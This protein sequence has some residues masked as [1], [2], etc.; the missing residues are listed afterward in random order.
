ME[1]TE[2]LL[3]LVALLLDAKEPLTWKQIR[4]A[5]PDDY[6]QG[7]VEATERK[8]ERDKAELLELG[9]PIKYTQAAEDVD[10]GYTLD[11]DA[12]YLPKLQLGPDEMAVLYAAGSAAL[13][14][15]AFPGSSDLAHALRKI[16]FFA[17]P[18]PPA[19]KVRLELGG[20]A[21][22]KDLPARLDALWSAISDRKFIEIDY[23]SPRQ[24]EVT[25]RRVDPYG[26]ALRRGLWSLVGYCH[27]RKGVRTFHVHRVREL[28]V[29]TKNP[30]TPDYQVPK[31]FAL[32]DYVASFPWQ[33][34]FH[35]RVDVE[36]QLKGHLAALAE[37]SFPGS[38]TSGDGKV[39]VA[40]TDLEGL[41]R[42]V[43]SL[44]ADARVLGPPEA[45]KRH[46]EMA[47]AISRL[48]QGSS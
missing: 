26:L 39:T 14:S 23:F 31:D 6:A 43:L 32:D 8:F 21:E 18:K 47:E 46:R 5:F 45:V 17:G 15:G 13:A 3:D 10:D 20:V 40:A 48:H 44:G 37:K 25:H 24:K 29:N 7:S 4:A 38:P 27:L 30:K 2:R 41:L 34:R 42:F 1:R 12:Y 11:K 9:I 19:P 28:T 36:L 22:T 35:P 16:G 33:H